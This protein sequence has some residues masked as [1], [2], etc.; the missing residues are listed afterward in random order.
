MPQFLSDYRVKRVW[1]RDFLCREVEELPADPF[2]LV[3]DPEIIE[4]LGR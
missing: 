3:R 4:R 1:S 2:D